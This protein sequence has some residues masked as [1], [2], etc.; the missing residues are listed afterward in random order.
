MIEK[1]TAAV[2]VKFTDEDSADL[3]ALA[4]ARGMEVS[5]YIRYLVIADRD[6]AHREWSALN[7]IFCPSCEADKDY[8]E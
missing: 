4:A 3:R 7:R 6:R 8:R 2:T 1:L 5:E